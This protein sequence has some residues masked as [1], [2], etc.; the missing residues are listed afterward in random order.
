M[1]IHSI[2]QNCTWEK[3]AKTKRYKAK[4]SGGRGMPDILLFLW[5]KYMSQVCKLAT[6]VESNRELLSS[7]L[8]SNSCDS[9]PARDEAP[10]ILLVAR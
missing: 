3:V 2:R 10:R 9:A 7:I 6:G 1:K 8:Q 5:A 4:W